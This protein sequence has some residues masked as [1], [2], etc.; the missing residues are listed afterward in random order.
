[1]PPVTNAVWQPSNHPI[2]ASDPYCL[3]SSCRPNHFMFKR[4]DSRERRESVSPPAAWKDAY[5]KMC[6][7]PLC[8]QN[9]MTAGLVDCKRCYDWLWSTNGSWTFLSFELVFN[10]GPLLCGGIYLKPF[11]AKRFIPSSTEL[12]GG[13]KQKWI[14]AINCKYW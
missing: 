1:M 14:T 10:H 9:T 13:G 4:P 7:C 2:S 6:P 8:W 5:V 11:R 12:N 3:H